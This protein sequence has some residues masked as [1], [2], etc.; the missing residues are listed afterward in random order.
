MKLDSLKLSQELIKYNSVSGTESGVID[1]LSEK[2]SEIGFKCD[3]VRFE[4]DGSYAVKNLH[5]LYNPDRKS[6][7]FYFAGH[8]D[9]VPIGDEKAWKYPPFEGRVIDDILYGR[10]VVDMKGAIA[11]FFCAASEFIQEFPSA[12]F[13]IGFLITDDEEADATNGTK[14][15]LEWMKE[16]NKKMSACLVGEPTNP[17]KLGEE[18]KIGRRG[19]VS[20]SLKV[21]GV[22]GHVAY[23]QNANNPITSLVNTLKLLKDY[24]LDNGNR[25]FDPSNLEI[26]NISSSGAGS[27]V[28]PAYATA[29]FNVRFNNE[30]DSASIISWVEYVC[31]MAGKFEL[32]HRISGESFITEPGILSDIAILA[33]EEETGSKP[34]ISTSG[35]TSDARFIKDF[36]PVIEFGLINKTA[37]HVDENIAV[38][39]IYKLK[40]IYKK[41]LILY[42]TR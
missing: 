36:C 8:T 32:S 11:A 27:N 15:M 18:V 4:G 14:K 39:D 19:S 40:E 35:G 3:V 38:N 2:L 6:R 16:N 17:T 30:H 29:N 7:T 5:A 34:K 21:I 23:P 12:D 25:F 13:G 20:F 22:Q 42:G 9:V 41:I 1:F 26:T 24:K 37:H 10:G 33:I 31:R 28:I